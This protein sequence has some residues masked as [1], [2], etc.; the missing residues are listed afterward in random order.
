MLPL[1]LMAVA[2]PPVCHAPFPLDET[3]AV[4]QA[5]LDERLEQFGLGEA[6]REKRLAVAVVDLT[7]DDEV[8]VAAVNPDHML[9]AASLPK[10]AILLAVAELANEGRV[11]WDLTFPYRLGKMITISNNA[12][13]SW[14]WDVATPAG[15]AEV[16]QRPRYCLYE[17]PDGGLWCGRPFRKSA[18]SLRDPLFHISHGAT[19][20]QVAR[21]YVML[22][23]GDLVSDYW[24]ERMLSLMAPPEYFHKFV[25]ALG[26]RRGVEFVARKSGT[27]RTFHADSAIVQHFSKRYVIV[28]LADHPD[29]EVMLRRVGRIVD[30]LIMAGEHRQPR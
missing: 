23:H 13:A 14:G 2:A 30:D 10:I 16:L 3:D 27:W 8:Y 11:D 5:Q 22:D 19:A 1:L 20:R 29:G 21:F 4:L 6:V 24:S 9:Y 7:R 12:Y 25:A 18:R 17:R 26:G 28:G 15:I